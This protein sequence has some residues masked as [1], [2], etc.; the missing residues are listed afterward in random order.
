ML[1]RKRRQSYW[2]DV[3]L[4]RGSDTNKAV[5]M[6]E[7]NGSVNFLIMDVESIE[8]TYDDS[9]GVHRGAVDIVTKDWSRRPAKESEVEK[10][11]DIIEG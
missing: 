7:V 5:L 8:L 2:W 10:L 4:T 9:D 1:N 11:L 6:Y 3:P